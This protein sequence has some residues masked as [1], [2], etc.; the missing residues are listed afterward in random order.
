MGLRRRRVRFVREGEQRWVQWR[1][2]GGKTWKALWFGSWVR[3]S[4]FLEMEWPWWPAVGRSAGTLWSALTV[5]LC[6]S[7]WA[8]V[9]VP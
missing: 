8:Q 9:L 3:G 1:K 4:L 2:K 6:P 5:S 7:R